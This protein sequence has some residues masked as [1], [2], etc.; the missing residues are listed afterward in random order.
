M[1]FTVKYKKL[2]LTGNL[3]GLTFVDKIKTSFPHDYYIGKEYV[4][5][6]TGNLI[7]IIES[8]IIGRS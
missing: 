6:G 2:F 8:N 4:E 1:L 7:R 3:K 5:V